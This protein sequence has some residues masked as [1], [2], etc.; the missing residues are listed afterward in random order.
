MGKET[1]WSQTL[2]REG[3]PVLELSMVLPAP[4]ETGPGGV[5]MARYY[6]RLGE[7]W[8][9]RWTERLYPRACAALEEARAGSRPFRPWRAS[10]TYRAAWS[11]EE[12][13][14]LWVDATEVRDKGRPLTVRTAGTWRRET[15]DL[16]RLPEVLP[17]RKGWRR[18][19]LEEVR[20]Q[21]GARLASGESLL[22]ADAAE[23]AAAQFSPRRFYLTEEGPVL[24]YPMYAL[25]SPAEGIPV[26]SLIGK[27]NFPPEK[28]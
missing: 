24:F 10:L 11:D 27:K 22:Y 23:R 18:Q 20:R 9:A 15:G 28:T 12:L 17:G 7:L 13:A 14:S 26:F 1:T 5:R 21:I 8:R 3:E 25:G 16:L 4:E 2:E 19:V 6:R